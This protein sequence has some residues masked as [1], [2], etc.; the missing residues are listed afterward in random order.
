MIL[1]EFAPSPLKKKEEKKKKTGEL[2][3]QIVC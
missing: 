2:C 3:G 1:R